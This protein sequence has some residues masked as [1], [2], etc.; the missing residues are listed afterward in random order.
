MV[1][2]MNEICSS[3]FYIF[4]VLNILSYV[5]ES[6]PATTTSSKVTNT[7]TYDEGFIDLYTS[8]IDVATNKD[9]K[10]IK[11]SNDIVIALDLPFTHVHKKN[12]SSTKHKKQQTEESERSRVVPTADR[13]ASAAALAVH[14]VNKNPNL[15]AGYRLRYAWDSKQTDT[16]CDALTAKNMMTKQA[17]H[18]NVS[19]FVGFQ[20][21]CH[22][23]SKIASQAN[24]PLISPVRI[25][26]ITF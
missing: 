24:L 26:F 10:K 14:D 4:L 9:T 7:F 25:F 21:H 3:S 22:N 8:T 20:C 16:Q 13:Y 11:R 5:V 15:L 17:L 2:P 18:Q 12:P 6:K 19:G 23:V 1:H